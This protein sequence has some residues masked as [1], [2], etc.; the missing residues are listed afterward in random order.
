MKTKTECSD[1]FMQSNP[2]GYQ[3]PLEEDIFSDLFMKAREGNPLSD[4]DVLQ[5]FIRGMEPDEE[6]RLNEIAA[7]VLVELDPLL[8][9]FEVR[10]VQAVTIPVN[11]ATLLTGNWHG[12]T[13]N[14]G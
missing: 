3:T 1:E 7:R 9:R 11:V 2:P 14:F 10:V 8:K 4:K 12:V 5:A 6:D 13:G